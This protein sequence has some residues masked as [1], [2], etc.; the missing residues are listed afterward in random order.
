MCVLL[1]LDGV[2]NRYQLFVLMDDAVEFNYILTHFLLAVSLLER[3]L[4]KSPTL[5]IN[6]SFLLTVLLIW[7]HVFLRHTCICLNMYMFIEHLHIRNII[8]TG[9][10]SML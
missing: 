1:L 5:T 10:L 6:P 7:P 4:V 8:S 3:V 2:V 9:P